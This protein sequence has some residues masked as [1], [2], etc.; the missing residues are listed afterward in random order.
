MNWPW[1][2]PGRV[3]VVGGLAGF[4]AGLLTLGVGSRL[5]MRIAAVAAGSAAQGRETEAGAIVGQITFEGTA[6]LVGAGAMVGVLLG[7]VYMAL[8]RW[9]PHRGEIYGAFLTLTVSARLVSDEN[10]DFKILGNPTL[11]MVMLLVLG[12]LFGLVFVP[13]AEAIERR[14]PRQPVGLLLALIYTAP[15]VLL[16]VMSVLFMTNLE[17]GGFLMAGAAATIVTLRKFR[18]TWIRSAAL[19][20]SVR[21]L[22]VG[23]ALAGTAVLVSDARGILRG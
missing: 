20:R 16:A 6:F 17:P 1:L 12:L 2:L 19:D 5:A 9:M 18:P 8:R 4:P 22:L 7:V 13:L 23:A 21:V 10:I 3:M 14:M 15:L 11:S